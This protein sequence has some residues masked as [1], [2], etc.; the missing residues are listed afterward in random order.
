MLCMTRFTILRPSRAPD[1]FLRAA[2]LRQCVLAASG[3]GLHDERKRR[4]SSNNPV[5]RPKGAYRCVP[6][7]GRSFARLRITTN[8]SGNASNEHQSASNG[9]GHFTS[10]AKEQRR[11]TPQRAGCAAS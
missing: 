10:T 7:M 9:D 1:D 2:K 8:G 5:L 6:F 3:M 11:L 4:L